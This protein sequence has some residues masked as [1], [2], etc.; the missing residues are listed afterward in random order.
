MPHLCSVTTA[1]KH[2]TIE[3]NERTR[4]LTR[5]WSFFLSCSA[6]I[7]KR[8]TNNNLMH[9][10]YGVALVGRIL[11]ANKSPVA[12]VTTSRSGFILPQI[13]IIQS[14]PWSVK[15]SGAP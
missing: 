15:Y 4:K 14:F 2:N 13:I 3:Y 9:V 10:I 1:N 7:N 8:A 11:A 12:D 6:A 5:F